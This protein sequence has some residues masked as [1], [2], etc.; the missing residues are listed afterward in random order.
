[1]LDRKLI[2]NLL[3]IILYIGLGTHVSPFNKY[4][5]HKIA[6]KPSVKFKDIWFFLLSLLTY[7][8][9]QIKALAIFFYKY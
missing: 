3:S 2:Q 4:K 8:S 5:T 1:M 6:K 9:T 7:V